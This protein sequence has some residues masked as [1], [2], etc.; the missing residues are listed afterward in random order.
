MSNRK[1]LADKS[2]I[3]LESISQKALEYYI[4]EGATAAELYNE[5][6]MKCDKLL[7]DFCVKVDD[8]ELAVQDNLEFETE[9]KE[10]ATAFNN[11]ITAYSK[12]FRSN[13]NLEALKIEDNEVERVKQYLETLNEFSDLL[14][15]LPK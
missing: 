11:L 15:N 7:N 4:M 1:F 10:Y 9:C 5:V 12:R 6:K 13:K 3:Q 14:D 2:W 8:A